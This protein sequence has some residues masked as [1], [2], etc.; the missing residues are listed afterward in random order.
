[1]VK[2]QIKLLQFLQVIKIIVYHFF[3]VTIGNY[4]Y[5]VHY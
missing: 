2:N 3:T 4:C 1:M 5:T